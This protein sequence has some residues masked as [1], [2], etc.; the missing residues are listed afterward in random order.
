MPQSD[1]LYLGSG[2]DGDDLDP[3]ERLASVGLTG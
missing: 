1:T 2:L 3:F